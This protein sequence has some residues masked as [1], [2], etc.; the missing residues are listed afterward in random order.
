MFCSILASFIRNTHWVSLGIVFKSRIVFTK[1]YQKR[2]HSLCSCCL[3]SFWL[4]FF[5]AFLRSE[6]PFG[7]ILKSRTAKMTFCE[8]VRKRTVIYVFIPNAHCMY[9]AF[10]SHQ[11]TSLTDRTMSHAPTDHVSTMLGS[12]F[13]LVTQ[14]ITPSLPHFN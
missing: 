9:D 14:L 7:E 6:W 2:C 8:F 11:Q 10:V 3:F 4:V 5:F 12:F 1:Y 13:I